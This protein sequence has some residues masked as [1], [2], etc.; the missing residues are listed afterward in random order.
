MDMERSTDL[1]LRYMLLRD[2]PEVAAIDRASFIPPWPATSYRFEI[3]ES[4]ISYMVVLE[5]DVLQPVQ[6][7]KRLW[8]NLRGQ[9]DIM[10]EQGIIV[11]Y[12]GLWKIGDEAHISTIASHPGY[13]G[14]KFG[15]ILLA[16]MIARALKLGAAYV[17]LEV[18]VSN[19]IA[20]N[21][22]FKYSFEIVG[23]K[24]E[25]YRNDKE[26]AYDMRLRFSDVTIA[27]FQQLYMELQERVAFRDRYSQTPHPRFG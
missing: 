3:N 14:N 19:T 10:D 15:E 27:R 16:G 23:V 7:I 1:T 25:Y 26:D 6:G 11:G 9:A 2:V 17:V 22:Y 24:A 20:Q 4:N 21:L 5:K 13:R 18:R 12:G 8:Y